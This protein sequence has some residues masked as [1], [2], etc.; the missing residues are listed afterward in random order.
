MEHHVIHSL[1][2][3]HNFWAH[4]PVLFLMYNHIHIN[5]GEG[6][7]NAEQAVPLPNHKITTA[8][9]LYFLCA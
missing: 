8:N 2:L 6:D 9:K 7:I 5:F 3:L 4:S 1:H